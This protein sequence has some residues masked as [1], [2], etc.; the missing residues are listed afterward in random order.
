M[1]KKNAVGIIL[2]LLLH[3]LLFSCK[4]QSD[5]RP[6][7]VNPTKVVT[8]IRIVGFMPSEIRNTIIYE[9]KKNSDFHDE[10]KA[11]PLKVISHGKNY[12]DVYSV[13]SLCVLNDWLLIVNDS[14]IY[15][16]TEQEV[17]PVPHATTLSIHWVNSIKTYNINGIDNTLNMI[18]T[19]KSDGI[20]M[21]TDTIQ[22][23][24]KQ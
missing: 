3:S 9:Y 6:E 1:K 8:Y 17:E 2:F 11:I 21:K 4:L 16:I 14:V 10:I 12:V 23:K 13:D 22:I 15:K 7:D 5:N 18:A 19:K 20:T 24:H